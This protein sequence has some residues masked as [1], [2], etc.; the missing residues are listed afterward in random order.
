[1][2]VPDPAPADPEDPVWSQSIYDELRVLA[3]QQLRGQ[4]AHTLQPTAL[5]HEAFLRLHRAG[6]DGV[7]QRRRFFALAG[8]VMRSVLVDHERRR[9][10][11]K[12]DGG[13]R[14]SLSAVLPG[15]EAPSLDVLAVEEALVELARLDPELVEVV[16]LLLF[17]GKNAAEIAEIRGVSSRTVERGWRVARA[18]LQSRLGESGDAGGEN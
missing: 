6:A 8:K 1:M 16:E 15:F 4:G 13:E 3:A 9:R 17:A 18:F 10:A 11:L 12:R 7:E 2:S 14:L 5:V